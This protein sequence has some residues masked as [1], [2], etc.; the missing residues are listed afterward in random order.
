MAKYPLSVST[1]ACDRESDWVELASEMARVLSAPYEG[2]G[3][4]R[5]LYRYAWV[6]SMVRLHFL[7]LSSVTP[8]R[9][10][11]RGPGADSPAELLR[12]PWGTLRAASDLPSFCMGVWGATFSVM[13]AFVVLV[14]EEPPRCS[15]C[16]A[17]ENMSRAR[18]T[19]L[20]RRFLSVGAEA[21][22]DLRSMEAEPLLVVFVAPAAALS[23]TGAAGFGASLL[24][25]V[26]MVEFS[27][28][29]ALPNIFES[30][31]PWALRRLLPASLD[32][33]WRLLTGW[34]WWRRRRWAAAADS[35]SYEISGARGTRMSRKDVDRR[36]GKS[37][38][39]SRC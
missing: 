30:R 37:R 31:P 23:A 32:D 21:S 35:R 14:G 2:A 1:T 16:F 7:F 18:D 29:F 13:V 38:G 19:P 8:T 24:A 33:G 9:K 12:E 15:D 6:S 34:W 26:S 4:L 20:L 22:L 36:K 10:V 5:K 17:L 11:D 25:G 28:S 3:V 39:S 27:S